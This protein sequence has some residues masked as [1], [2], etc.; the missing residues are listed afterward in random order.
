VHGPWSDPNTVISNSIPFSFNS[1]QFI[2]L[3]HPNIA[4]LQH[5]MQTLTCSYGVAEA[6][7]GR[8]DSSNIDAG[9]ATVRN[10][11][12]ASRSAPSI[13]AEVPVVCHLEV[14]TS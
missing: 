10:R 11:R 12:L 3:K 5:Q 14:N 2:R 4:T 8:L 13:F 7:A 1:I 6:Q 9:S